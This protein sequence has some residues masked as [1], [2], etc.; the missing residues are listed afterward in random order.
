MSKASKEKFDIL[1]HI[2]DRKTGRMIAENPY[3]LRKHHGVDYFERPKGSG[4]LYF[5]NNE[6]A[7]RYEAGKFLPDAAHKE[8]VKPLNEKELVAQAIAA[9][10]DENAK[11][12]AE[13]NE[14]KREKKFAA[15]EDADK[16]AKEIAP[17]LDKV[18]SGKSKKKEI[19]ENV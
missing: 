18:L 9:K 2:R 7:G 5:G 16:A 19:Q 13:L 10:D 12:K 14:I 4:N 8:W 15:V 6:P 1:V 3:V 17:K 11:L